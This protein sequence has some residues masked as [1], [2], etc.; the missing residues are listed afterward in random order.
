MIFIANTAGHVVQ[1]LQIQLQGPSTARQQQL[2]SRFAMHCFCLKLFIEIE[3]ISIV[4]ASSLLSD[5]QPQS[6]LSSRLAAA[7]KKVLNLL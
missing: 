1:S 4:D 3:S 5:F 6:C 7:E 2:F